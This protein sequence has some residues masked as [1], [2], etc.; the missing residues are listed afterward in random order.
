MSLLRSVAVLAATLA[1]LLGLAALAVPE[2]DRVRFV[3]PPAIV[4][5]RQPLV[6]QVQIEPHPD[7]RLL[8]L[9]AADDLS[10]VRGSS[11]QLDGDSAH[12]TR[13][14][15]WAEGLPTGRFLLIAALYGVG[16]EVARDTVPIEVVP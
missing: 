4:R 15:R 13:W 8:M 2:A 12:R 16:G 9:V 5:E 10:D 3:R 11:E 6:L 14:V 1:I 7:N